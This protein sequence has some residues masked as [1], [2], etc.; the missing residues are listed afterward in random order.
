MDESAGWSGSRAD[1]IWKSVRVKKYAQVV[2]GIANEWK[3]S[4]GSTMVGD[5]GINKREATWK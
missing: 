4:S 5:G 1:H 2:P 3:L